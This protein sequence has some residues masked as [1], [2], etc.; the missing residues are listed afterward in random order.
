[1]DEAAMY[2]PQPTQVSVNQEEYKKFCYLIKVMDA[3][4]R[5]DRRAEEDIQH[6]KSTQ[7]ITAERR[8]DWTTVSRFVAPQL[9]ISFLRGSE[10]WEDERK[11]REFPHSVIIARTA[12]VV[13]LDEVFELTLE[14]EAVDN[15]VPD[16]SQVF[17]QLR[18]LA[19]S[20]KGMTAL[21]VEPTIRKLERALKTK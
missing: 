10:R 15:D 3:L 12:F 9:L 20:S 6:F 14:V 1:M 11:F 13:V 17:S 16:F 21:D 7:G 8:F 4:D 19:Q 2:E 5:A 18:L